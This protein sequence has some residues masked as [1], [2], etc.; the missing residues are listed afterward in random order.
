MLCLVEGFRRYAT[1][2]KN[3][4]SWNR[5][6]NFWNFAVLRLKRHGLW[7]VWE[8]S[9]FFVSFPTD[10]ATRW[11]ISAVHRA[12]IPA[13][14]QRSVFVSCSQLAVFIYYA[15]WKPQKQWVTLDE[16][17]WNSPLTY[18]PNRREE[19]WRFVSYMFVHAGWAT[20]ALF[21]IDNNSMKSLTGLDGNAWANSHPPWLNSCC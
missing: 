20:E 15:V 4:C 2:N 3:S 11:G 5:Q 19:A 7:L 17:V 6:S 1:T 8:K 21:F 9:L 12:P 14:S 16:G 18:Q 13:K 10:S